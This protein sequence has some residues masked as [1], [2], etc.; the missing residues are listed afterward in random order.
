MNNVYNS[1]KVNCKIRQQ[2]V[3]PTIEKKCY[4]TAYTGMYRNVVTGQMHVHQRST[5]I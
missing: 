1:K 5:T 2:Q 4:K 3:F